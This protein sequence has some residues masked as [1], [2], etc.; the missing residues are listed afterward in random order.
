MAF[1]RRGKAA[2]GQRDSLGKA[3]ALGQNVNDRFLARQADPIMLGPTFDHDEKRRRRVVLPVQHLVRFQ[4]HRS[5]RGDDVLH[6]LRFEAA[7]NGNARDDLEI[8][9]GWV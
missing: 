6:R 5:R 4:H 7:E 3:V 8:G 9:G 1:S 2:S